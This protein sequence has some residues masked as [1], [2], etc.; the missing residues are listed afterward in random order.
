M[1]AADVKLFLA[2]T[3]T[4]QDALLHKQE[5][6]SQESL[7][8]QRLVCLRELDQCCASHTHKLYF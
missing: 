5:D 6:I 2:K 7:V 4:S 8:G 1:E 3:L